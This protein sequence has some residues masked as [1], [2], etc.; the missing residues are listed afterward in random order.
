MF[1][2]HFAFCVLGFVAGLRPSTLRPLR[3]D[4]DVLWDEGAILIRQSHTHGDEVMDITKTAQ[5]QR[6]GLP[7]DLV[8]ILRS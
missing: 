4:N 3:R 5:D 2:Q 6:I 1:P 7:V 8:E